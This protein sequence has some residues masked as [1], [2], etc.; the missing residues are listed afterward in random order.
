MIAI[1]INS[2]WDG[3]KE[4]DITCITDIRSG[5]GDEKEYQYIPK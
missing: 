4:K 1:E 3:S 2:V 5:G